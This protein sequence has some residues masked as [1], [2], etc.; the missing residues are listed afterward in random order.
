MQVNKGGNV[1]SSVVGST[2]NKINE[3][4]TRPSL[5]CLSS[6]STT[7]IHTLFFIW[8]LNW[9]EQSAE[10]HRLQTELDGIQNDFSAASSQIVRFQ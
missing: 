9:L 6:S 2:G 4:T 10:V 3:M 7:V 1:R 5:N 8:N